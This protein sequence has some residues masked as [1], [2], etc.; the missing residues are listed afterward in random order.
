MNKNIKQ[1]ILASLTADSYCL[2]S[3]WIYDEEQL[4]N[5]PISW[6]TLNSPQAMWHKGKDK[7]DFTHYGDQ[8]FFLLEYMVN[9]KSFDK[10]DFYSFWSKK[11]S[12]YEGYV[13]GATRK[14]LE[15]MNSESNDLSICGRLSPLLINADTKEAFLKNVDEF[16]SITHN[17]K[18]AKT[19][20]AFF[21]E[22]LYDSI[23][24][25]DI[26][27]NIQNLKNKYPALEKWIDDGVN[28]KDTDT[29][30][31]IR[32]FGPACGINGG[33]AGVIHLLSL[34]DDFTTLMIKNAKAGGDSSARGMVVAMIL[35]SQDDFIENKEWTNEINNIADIRKL[36]NATV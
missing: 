5:L 8:T 9:N 16:V 30:S 11:M 15:N 3:H 14:A 26:K 7:G 36:L 33:F 35:A 34:D 21:A 27:N 23:E 28:S 6:E 12:D 10:D 2:G 18:L 13:D 22:L 20:G 19:A 17:S 4:K 31:A 29:S 25:Q 24:N 1:S 32:E